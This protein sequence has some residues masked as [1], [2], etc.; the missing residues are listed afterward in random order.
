MS[1]ALWAQGPRV[2]VTSTQ[3]AEAYVSRV[4]DL[5]GL[6]IDLNAASADDLTALV[7]ISPEE[8]RR[9]VAHRRRSG[10][11]RRKEDLRGLPGLSPET[12]EAIAPYVCVARPRRPIAQVRLRVTRPSGSANSPQQFRLSQ[13]AEVD[14]QGCAR[15]YVSTERDPG[16]AG[17]A[18]FWTAH[19][20]TSRVPGTRR[21]VAGDIRHGFG[22]GLVHSRG[23]RAAIGL[24]STSAGQSQRVGYRS[25]TESGALR[26]VWAEG[27]VGSVRWAFVAATAAWD[28]AVDENGNA[29]IRGDGQ[30]VSETEKERRNALPERVCGT[31]LWVDT[32]SLLVGLAAH[33]TVFGL[34]LAGPG[35][36][37]AQQRVCS[38]D[39]RAR[40]PGLVVFGEAA[41]DGRRNA[42]W[43]AGAKGG[44]KK[45]QVTVA[46]RRYGA[47]YLALRAA[48]VSAYSGLPHNEWGLFSGL[49]WKPRRSTRCEASV[50]RHGRLQPAGN[51]GVPG[52]GSRTTFALR[53][54]LGRKA[55]AS[56][57]ISARE[58][59]VYTGGSAGR[60]AS[61]RFTT[62]LDTN[63][64]WGR[65]RSWAALTRSRS[66]AREGFGRAVGGGIVW[67]KSGGLDLSACASL[68]HTTCYDARVYTFEP[69][70]W[71]GSRLVV[72]SGRVATVGL[73][74]RWLGKLFSVSARYSL[75]RTADATTSSWSLQVHTRTSEGR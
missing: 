16:E 50:D 53:Q 8:A 34:P 41:C 31:R 17:M 74:A 69:D 19:V 64:S 32:A 62:R 23:E 71:G 55:V 5:E 67:G 39:G 13:R 40:L 61:F 1:V 57:A 42:A 68:T 60:R 29:A 44:G 63:P 36:P 65:V 9:I 38:L 54:R 20:I 51:L 26:G 3:E 18:D 75:K 56:L 47:E 30:H 72:L 52:R 66:P 11:Y 33:R 28:A 24:S 25:S 49:V 6:Q 14:I 7:W 59:S 2:P 4:Q 70:V 46:T 10:G 37:V 45:L 21:V 15:V 12:Y 22:Q 58:R 35:G 48:P 73:R 27:G 43:T